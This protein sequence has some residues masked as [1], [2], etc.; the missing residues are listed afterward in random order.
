MNGDPPE[1][2]HQPSTWSVASMFN[3]AVAPGRNVPVSNPRGWSIPL[4]AL[5]VQAT[6]ASSGSTPQLVT[7][8]CAE[9]GRDRESQ[10]G[11]KSLASVHGQLFSRHSLIGGQWSE[12]ST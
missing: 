12:P 5:R 11:L 6:N 9:N 4:A 8:R 2:W 10:F 7:A 1:V 3:D